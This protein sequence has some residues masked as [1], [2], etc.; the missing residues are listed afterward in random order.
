MSRGWRPGWLLG[1]LTD[2]RRGLRAVGGP[3]VLV[4]CGVVRGVGRDL[5]QPMSDDLAD[6]LRHGDEQGWDES[7][8][9]L[10]GEAADRIE[11]LDAEVKRLKFAVVRYRARGGRPDE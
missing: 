6:R 10:M 9:G 1:G 7:G 3:G 11:E 4:L 8:S 2:D 5:G